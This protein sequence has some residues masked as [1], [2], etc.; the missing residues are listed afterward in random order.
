MIVNKSIENIQN[1]NGEYWFSTDYCI[2]FNILLVHFIDM[3]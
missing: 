2:D 1:H 3:I